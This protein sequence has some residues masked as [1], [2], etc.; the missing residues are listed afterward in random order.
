MCV[1]WVWR[2]E[3]SAFTFLWEPVW[4]MHF[5]KQQQKWAE[6]VKECVWVMLLLS[7]REASGQCSELNKGKQL[8]WRGCRAKWISHTYPFLLLF[9]SRYVTSNSLH[10]RDMQHAGL[11]CPSLSPGVCSN[12][13]PLSWWCHPTISS[14]VAVYFYPLFFR[15][16][17]YLGHHRALSRVPCAA[18]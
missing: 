1:P 13:C 5:K 12:S 9:F 11:P 7:N 18:E 8:G 10:P 6:S 14:S 17:F 4:P 15:F 2:E 16:P 3:W